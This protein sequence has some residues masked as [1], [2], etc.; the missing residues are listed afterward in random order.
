M[1]IQV[2]LVDCNG[3]EIGQSISLVADLN[4]RK[5]LRSTICPPDLP[6]RA[7]VRDVLVQSDPSDE[8]EKY[9]LIG[10]DQKLKGT[11]S[12]ILFQPRKIVRQPSVST[13]EAVA[14]NT[15]FHG[16]DTRE[17]KTA[18]RVLASSRIGAAYEISKRQVQSARDAGQSAPPLQ[19]VAVKA[20]GATQAETVYNSVGPANLQNSESRAGKELETELP[21]ANNAVE[22]KHQ[23]D[24]FDHTEEES[25]SVA[26]QE[27]KFRRASSHDKRLTSFHDL[28]YNQKIGDRAMVEARIAAITY[29]AEANMFCRPVCLSCFGPFYTHERERSSGSRLCPWCG[30][31]DLKFEYVVQVL[32]KDEK[33]GGVS[34]LLTGESAQ[35][36]FGGVSATDLYED[37]NG[38]WTVKKCCD[39]LMKQEKSLFFVLNIYRDDN[40][41]R[42]FSIMDVSTCEP[43]TRRAIE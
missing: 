12:T 16:S 21:Q 29:P 3:L 38:G 1:K 41:V 32:L 27:L 4:T 7:M 8:S 36:L 23:V 31:T 17:D 35:R 26:A 2:E 24:G 6:C 30:S 28:I 22:T 9:F 14:T 18:A 20:N 25:R 11:T 19:S 34:A 15:P 5:Y 39:E 42:H 43:E 37:N 33:N 40:E 10:C 13:A